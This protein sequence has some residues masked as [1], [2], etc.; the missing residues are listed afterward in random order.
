[1][2]KLYYSIG[3][4]CVNIILQKYSVTSLMDYHLPNCIECFPWI[5]HPDSWLAKF[6][7][8]CELA[9]IRQLRVTRTKNRPNPWSNK[10]Q[11]L[12]S[13]T[14]LCAEAVFLVSL[15]MSSFLAVN[16]VYGKSIKS[17]FLTENKLG[18]SSFTAWLKIRPMLLC[19]YSCEKKYEPVM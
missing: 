16:K 5:L 2:N 11:E 17:S 3:F 13:P 9:E 12:I 10:K 14:F 18:P 7:R 19:Q 1:M 4:H 15:R 8:W 6:W